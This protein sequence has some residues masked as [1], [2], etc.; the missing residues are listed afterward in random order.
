[1][2]RRATR[3]GS[4]AGAPET[5]DRGRSVRRALIANVAAVGAVAIALAVFHLRL[6]GYLNAHPPECY[7]IGFGCRPGAGFTT[8]LVGWFA[9]VPAILASWIATWVGWRLT[10]NASDVAARWGCWGPVGLL[11]VVASVAAFSWGAMG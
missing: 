2:R 1:M 8:L 6:Q 5:L 7:G 9:G 3:S 10:R 4:G 11:T